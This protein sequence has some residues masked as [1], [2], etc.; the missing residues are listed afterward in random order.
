M[1]EVH[2]IRGDGVENKRISQ[3]GFVIDY[4]S[5]LRQHDMGAFVMV[6]GEGRKEGRREGGR[7]GG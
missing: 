4:S 2:F 7:E 3:A 6:R 1:L 5:T